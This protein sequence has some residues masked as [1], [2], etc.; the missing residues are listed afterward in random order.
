[1]YTVA[2][3]RLQ[4]RRLARHAARGAAAVPADRAAAAGQDRPRTRHRPVRLVDHALHPHEIKRLIGVVEGGLSNPVP[5]GRRLVV[6]DPRPLI[7][8]HL[9]IEAHDIVREHGKLGS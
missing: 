6:V 9:G 5:V 8:G 3:Q 4:H 7:E 2:R 1:M